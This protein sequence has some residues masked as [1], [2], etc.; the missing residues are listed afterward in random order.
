MMVITPNGA[1]AKMILSAQ[2]MDWLVNCV[3]T[4]SPKRVRSLR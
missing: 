3:V 1:M 4:F 2:P